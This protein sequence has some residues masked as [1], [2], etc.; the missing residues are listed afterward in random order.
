MG[1]AEDKIIKGVTRSDIE[2]CISSAACK[3]MVMGFATLSSS[4]M[5]HAGATIA[6]PAVKG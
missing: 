6:T 3:S 1:H 4:A 2:W 5:C